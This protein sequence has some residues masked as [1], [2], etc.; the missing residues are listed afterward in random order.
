MED[1]EGWV[2][3][4]QQ[5]TYA[6]RQLG[7]FSEKLPLLPNKDNSKG[8]NKSFRNVASTDI[9]NG[10]LSQEEL[11]AKKYGLQD[12]AKTIDYMGSLSLTL[13]N[14]ID[15]YKIYCYINKCQ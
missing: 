4:Q 3:N 10:E 12:P 13:N 9:L 8:M 6:G 7:T 15:I 2:T 14:V 1:L 11:H 5:K